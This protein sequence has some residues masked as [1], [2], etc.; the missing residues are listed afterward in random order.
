M[1]EV[2]LKIN[3][4]KVICKAGDRLIDVAQKEGN[5]IPRFCYHPALSVVASCRMCLVEIEGCKKSQPACSMIVREGMVVETQSA[6]VISDQKAMMQFMLVNHPL[7]CPICDQGGEC[8]LQDTAMGYG[9]GYADVSMPKRTVVDEDLGALVATDMSLC[10]HCSRCVRFGHE[11]AGIPDLGLMNRSDGTLIGTYLKSGLRSELSGNM[12]D[13]CPVGAL[14]SKPLKFKGRSWGFL[15]HDGVSAHDCLGSNL[16]YHT[17]AKGY[18][19]LSDLMRTVPKTNPFLNDIWLSDRDR[20]AYQGVQ[21]ESRLLKPKVKQKGEWVD[22]SWDEVLKLIMTSFQALTVSEK[23]NSG[24]W[25]SSQTTLEEGYLLQALFRDMGIYNIDHRVNSFSQIEDFLRPSHINLHDFKS[26]DAIVLL[27]CNIR[28]E[29]PLMAYHIKEAIALGTKVLSLGAISHDYHFEHDCILT[30]SQSLASRLFTSLL[31]KE[32]G[33]HEWMK[34][35]NI[36]FILGEEA[37]THPQA[38]EIKNIVHNFCKQPHQYL[39]LTQGPNALGLKAAGCVPNMGDFNK[40]TKQGMDYCQ[41]LNSDMKLLWLHQLD[42]N[43]DV[44]DAK[45][46]KKMLKEAFVISLSSYDTDGIREVSD[47]ILPLALPQENNGSYVNYLGMLQSF[48]VATRARSE[49]KMGY[50]IYEVLASLMDYKTVDFETLQADLNLRYKKMKWPNIEISKPSKP[51]NLTAKWIRLGLSSW[52]RHDP[53]LRHAKALQVAYPVN[54]AM[55]VHHEMN[56]LPNYQSS[57][58]VAKYT[59]L[60]EKMGTNYEEV[61]E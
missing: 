15:Q 50:S 33:G 40:K 43:Y 53:V 2:T 58:K 23:A 37:L 7:H 46:A 19:H 21:V 8:D 13:L 44:S 26:F 28:Y 38:F 3:G 18:D 51:K 61:V 48:G 27:G 4:K 47:I 39:F 41:M 20:F 54:N 60:C 14:T 10:I 57:D 49:V 29:Q 35:D 1:T 30:P 17:L 59:I 55:S 22:V 36:L 56:E 34:K 16:Y 5:Y 45:K 32:E 31:Q 24:A 25:L 9:V 11:I 6:K 12:I 52:V 42:P